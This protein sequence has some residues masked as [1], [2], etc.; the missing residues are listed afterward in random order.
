MDGLSYRAVAKKLKM[1][2]SVLTRWVAADTAR[3]AQVREARIASAKA[4]ADE[5]RQVIEDAKDPFALARAKELAHHLR[6]EASRANPRDY[7]DRVQNEHTGPE[8][9][10]LQVTDPSRPRITREEWLAAHGVKL[11]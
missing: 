2:V 11:P 6:W 3:A 1:N 9:G 4:F 10:P 7:G 8:G 5:A